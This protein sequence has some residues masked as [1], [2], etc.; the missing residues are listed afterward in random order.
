V[1]NLHWGFFADI[2]KQKD[3][4]LSNLLEQQL[5][6]FAT[7]GTPVGKQRSWIFDGFTNE[8]TYVNAALGHEYV[9]CR[10]G[11]WRKKSI[12]T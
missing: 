4:E 12:E 8:A 7:S 3:E 2:A 1:P 5:T 9:A 6:G 10:S 11:Y